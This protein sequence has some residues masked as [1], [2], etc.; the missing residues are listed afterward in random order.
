MELYIIIGLAVVV[1]AF[2]SPFLARLLYGDDMEDPED[3]PK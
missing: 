2:V 1:F 3:K